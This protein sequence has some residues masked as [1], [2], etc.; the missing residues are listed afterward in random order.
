MTIEEQNTR[1]ELTNLNNFSL[2]NLNI[3]ELKT[4]YSFKQGGRTVNISKADITRRFEDGATGPLY[5]SPG[6]VNSFGV[7]LY[8]SNGKVQSASLALCLQEGSFVESLKTLIRHCQEHVLHQKKEFKTA[9][10]T[11]PEALTKMNGLKY[12]IDRQTGEVDSRYGPTL[13]VKL[14]AFKQGGEVSA[15]WSKFY[16]TDSKQEVNPLDFVGKRCV[17]HPIIQ[18]DNIMKGSDIYLQLNVKEC[19][20]KEMRS[21]PQRSLLEGWETQQEVSLFGGC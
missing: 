19:F 21:S 20:I 5:I 3:D 2:A 16:D 9:A 14:K 1:T 17:V 4:A 12:K 18:V 6:P 10:L 11:S 13:R 7:S 15:I 8:E